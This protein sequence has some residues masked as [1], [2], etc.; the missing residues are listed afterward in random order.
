M[1]NREGW[2]KA[3]AK[4]RSPLPSGFLS[5]I[6]REKIFLARDGLIPL[7]RFFSRYPAPP[8]TY[9]GELLVHR[10]WGAF[11]PSRWR[12]R[13]R[14]YR[15][16]SRA[17]PGLPKEQTR[18]RA[19]MAFQFSRY[20]CSETFLEER[21]GAYKKSRVLQA[22]LRGGPPLG[23]FEHG[24]P[25]MGF[26][27]KAHHSLSQLFGR[28]ATPVSLAELKHF[29][30]LRDAYALDFNERFHCSDDANLHL[31]LS[32]GA[33]DPLEPLV[34]AKE[35]FERVSLY[36]GYFLSTFTGRE[37]RFWENAERDAMRR[38]LKSASRDWAAS[39]ALDRRKL[40]P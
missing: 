25:N 38:F 18:T 30:N 26:E 17:S 3:A 23:I 15:I 1:N 16:G 20:Y 5:R 37:A 31:L 27:L 33:V 6:P 40:F 2:H 39:F 35:H 34:K 8:K 22:A 21:A 24:E 19:V 7:L 36:H 10:D 13:C 11:V 32:R 14:L 12:A 29:T 4:L 28:R 9:R